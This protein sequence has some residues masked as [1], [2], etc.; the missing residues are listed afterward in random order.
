[1]TCHIKPEVP[2][3]VI[4]DPGRLRQIIVNLLGNAIK[5]TSSGEISLICDILEDE[6]NDPDSDNIFIHFAI[7]DTGIGIPTEKVETI[8][9][10]F[11]QVDSS[12]TRKFGGTGLGLSICRQLV[13][14]MAGRIWVESEYE[15]GSTFH[16]TVKFQVQPE[17]KVRRDAAEASSL[18]GLR[19]LIVDDNETNRLILREMVASWG[20][21]HKEA[22][23]GTTALSLL[24]EK[25]DANEPFDLVLLDAQMPEIDGFQVSRMIKDNPEFKN[26]KIIMLTSMGLLGDAERSK[27]AGIAVYLLKPVKRSDLFDA[28]IN[29][30]KPI[31]GHEFSVSDKLITGHSLREIRERKIPLILLGESNANRKEWYIKILVKEGYSVVTAKNGAKLLEIYQLHPF[32]LLIVEID[33]PGLDGVE[34]AK[35]IRESERAFCNDIRV[36]IIGMIGAEDDRDEKECIQ[37][38]IDSCLKKPIKSEDMLDTTKRILVGTGVLEKTDLLEPAK[39]EEPIIN[40][41]TINGEKMVEEWI[42]SGEGD[43]DI[44]KIIINGIKR[45]PGKI[46]S[47]ENAV[48]ADNH[49]NIKTVAHEIKGFSGNYGMMEIFSLTK[50]I[51]DEVKTNEYNINK[52]KHLFSEVKRVISLIPESY[53]ESK[54]KIVDFTVLVAEDNVEN[55]NLVG[56]L[57]KKL[58]VDYEFADNGKIA[59]Q[60]LDE[61]D[62][63]LL[64]LDMQMP[65]MDGLETIRHLREDEKHKNLHVI[66]VTANAIKGDE[67]KYINAGCDDYIS[68]PINKE[69][70]REKLGLQIKE[71]EKQ[72]N[73]KDPGSNGAVL[74]LNDEEREKL[75]LLIASLKKNCRL[76]NP[77]DVCLLADQ[78]VELVDGE[79]FQK[80]RERLYGAAEFFDDETVDGIVKELEAL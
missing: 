16:F 25:F 41:D 23:N 60:K 10:V 68:K 1:M 34:V 79:K 6:N 44:E 31:K 72:I 77:N 53:V 47:L 69:I 20:F 74:V 36:P 39:A 42:E 65:V 45:L 55:Q 73:V 22:H 57:L 38:G 9:D 7:T 2:T 71:K 14:M 15:K 11:S 27:K 52:I 63:D 32:D 8:F 30:M 80:I 12:T 5:F 64:L 29:L 48:N 35:L 61:K 26:I 37:A 66:S 59:L 17:Q 50:K 24:K 56:V 70:F 75:K 21:H 58:R 67:E 28:I 13:E 62:Y 19:A 4:G 49:H 40:Y 46:L 54:Q 78:L 3:F 76:F 51:E 43:P 18:K 33:L